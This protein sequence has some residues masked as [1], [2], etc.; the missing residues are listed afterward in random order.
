MATLQRAR[1]P[2]QQ[3]TLRIPLKTASASH[4]CPLN[5]R[6]RQP[7]LGW[8]RN[9]HGCW[10]PRGRMP[11][12][13]EEDQQGTAFASHSHTLSKSA[14]RTVATAVD[15]EPG[16]TLRRG[17]MLQYA[18]VRTC[19][20]RQWPTARRWRS[21]LCSVYHVCRL[22]RDHVAL[23]ATNVRNSMRADCEYYGPILIP[24]RVHFHARQRSREGPRVPCARACARVAFWLS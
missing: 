19:P 11:V 1:V 8:R 12:P 16:E 6:P 5:L 22:T 10:G 20:P 7:M 9:R 2:T 24:Q 15:T 17:I 13:N 14:R 4:C 21:S 3:A 23:H 18:Q